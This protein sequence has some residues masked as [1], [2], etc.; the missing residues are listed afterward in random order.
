MWDLAVRAAA[1]RVRK[2]DQSARSLCR[3]LILLHQ[4]AV[5][6]AENL[7]VRLAPA[8]CMRFVVNEGGTATFSQSH[9]DA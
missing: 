5:A 6:I 3:G 4:S 1:E 2:G 8:L 7:Q 9:S